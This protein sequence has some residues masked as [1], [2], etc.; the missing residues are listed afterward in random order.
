MPVTKNENGKYVISHELGQL[1]ELRQVQ[2]SLLSVISAACSSEDKEN[3]DF[4][5]NILQLTE[6]LKSTLISETQLME[7]QKLEDVQIM[8][9]VG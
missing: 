9:K 7:L 6:L 8:K 1:H 4:G 3:F 2:E 5:L